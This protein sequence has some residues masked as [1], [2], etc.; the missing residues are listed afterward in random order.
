MSFGAF[1]SRAAL[2]EGKPDQASE[3]RSCNVG[4]TVE[5]VGERRQLSSYQRKSGEHHG[6]SGVHG[7]ARRL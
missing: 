1:G 7:A 2:W 3:V 6:D 4:A 5:V